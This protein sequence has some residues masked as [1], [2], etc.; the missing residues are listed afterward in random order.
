MGKNREKIYAVQKVFRK[1]SRVKIKKQ[2][3]YSI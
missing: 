2:A 3:D 1:F